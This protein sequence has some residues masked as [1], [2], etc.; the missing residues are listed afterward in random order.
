MLVYR[1]ADD[2]E[3]TVLDDSMKALLKLNAE[4]RQSRQSFV[5]R[6][7]AGL[8]IFVLGVVVIAD[9]ALSRSGLRPWAGRCS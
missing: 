6:L 1:N 5:I 2:E 7:V 3:R 9:G 4:P 8:L